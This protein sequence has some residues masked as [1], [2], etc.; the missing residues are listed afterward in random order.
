MHVSDMDTDHVL[1]CVKLLV[2]RGWDK[3]ADLISKLLSEVRH[4]S[5]L[6]G[7]DALLYAAALRS[8]WIEYM[9]P[10]FYVLLTQLQARGVNFGLNECHRYFDKEVQCSSESLV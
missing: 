6:R 7:K 3:R 4:A 10:V 9:S 5:Q 1:N 8:G 2:R